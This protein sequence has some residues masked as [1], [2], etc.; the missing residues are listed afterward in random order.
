MDF[1]KPYILLNNDI[2]LEVS[3]HRSV[4]CYYN[5]RTNKYCFIKDLDYLKDKS[6][7]IKSNGGD[8]QLKCETGNGQSGGG[9]KELCA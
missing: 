5:I 4:G 1:L 9:N 3:T 8:P 6:N 2:S 7:Q